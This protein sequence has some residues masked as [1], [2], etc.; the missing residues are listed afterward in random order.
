MGQIKKFIVSDKPK[1][2]QFVLPV[3]YNYT[4]QPFYK[5]DGVHNVA[6]LQE[7]CNQFMEYCHQQ[8]IIKQKLIEEIKSL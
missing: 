3:T 7:L 4:T 6:E 8:A 1:L 2:D 5:G